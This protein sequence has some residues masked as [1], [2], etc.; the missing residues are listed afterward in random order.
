VRAREVEA[1]ANAMIEDGRAPKTVRNVISF[2]YSIFEEAIS[3]GL[4]RENPVRHATR[5]GRRR[6]GDAAP[7]LRFLT[8]E[9]LDRSARDP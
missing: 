3:R 5:P 6:S 4:I 2:H 7:D 1:L 9:E 8:I